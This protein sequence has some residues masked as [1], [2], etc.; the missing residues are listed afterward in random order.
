[1]WLKQFLS[2]GLI[3]SPSPSILY[4][5][6]LTHFSLGTISHPLRAK[7]VGRRSERGAGS[8]GERQVRAEGKPSVRRRLLRLCRQ[9]RRISVSERFFVA[10]TLQFSEIL[11]FPCW[12][13]HMTM[14]TSKPSYKHLKWTSNFMYLKLILFVYVLVLG[15]A[16]S[17]GFWFVDQFFAGS[18]WARPNTYIH[19]RGSN[20]SGN[21]DF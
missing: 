15:R 9:P 3:L 14:I 20:C 5:W 17:P 1:M 16:G 6:L 21:D 19:I 2:Q 8:G 13:V 10:Q 12:S 7:L 4:R 18:A 11:L